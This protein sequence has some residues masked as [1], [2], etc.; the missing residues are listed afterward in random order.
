MNQK[1]DVNLATMR[2]VKGMYFGGPS[3]S[4][5]DTWV[6][7]MTFALGGWDD[8]LVSPVWCQVCTAASS[9]YAA[10]LPT[11]L[12]VID[13]GFP[14]PYSTQVGDAMDDSPGVR[15]PA[16]QALAEYT[17]SATFTTWLMCDADTLDS[18]AVPLAKATWSIEFTFVA[19]SITNNNE[20]TVTYANH[21][22]A[23][24]VATTDFPSWNG[25]WPAS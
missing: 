21:P 1:G 10:D 2:G 16:A 5:G 6:P 14:Y 15:L 24:F 9:N 11:D 7:G 17:F 19:P 20:W 25:T 4:G 12:P 8:D 3:A 13:S 22:A 23:T 18:I